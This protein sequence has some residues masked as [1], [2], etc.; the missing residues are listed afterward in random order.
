MVRI[1]INGFGRIGR[2]VTRIACIT[3]GVEVVAVNELADSSTM[4]H[5]FKF[6][7]VH[8][9]YG[10]DVIAKEKS[11]EID[12]QDINYFSVKEPH[13]IPWEDADVDVVFECT[14]KFKDRR[15]ASQHLRPSLHKVVITAATTDDSVP[16]V[17]LGVNDHLIDP[18][19]DVISNAS[20]TTNNAAPMIKLIH[21]NF[22]IESCYITTVHSYTGDQRIH[23]A[24]H[25]DLRRAR[26]AALSIVPT[27]TGAAKALTRVFPDLAL[28]IGGCGIRV[29]VPDGSL[30]DM[31]CI[32]NA[33]TS[34]EEVNQLFRKWSE[35][36][37]AGIV[38]YTE[39]PIV[40]TDVLGDAH[41]CIFDAQ[42]T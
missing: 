35:E 16:M 34:V 31:T 3:P 26:A 33:S 15:V 38:K 5:L 8:G 19:W 28:Q 18:D 12:G 20:C 6:D 30:T 17:V 4:A 32:V 40:S 29:P 27:T 7:S 41:S 36:Q 37:M 14:G 22:G 23:D 9:K 21:E 39:E 10:G 42:L 13:L 24:P 1:G 11:L 2:M 25:T